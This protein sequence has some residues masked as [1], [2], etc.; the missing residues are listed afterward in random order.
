MDDRTNS[1][2]VAAS[3]NDLDAIRAIIARLED[4]DRVSSAS[5]TSSSCGTPAAA[6]V[7]DV[8]QTF[9]TSSLTVINTGLTQTNYLEII[10]EHRD[11][12]RADHQQPAHQRH[13][14][15]T[16]TQLMPVIEQL[17][18]VPLQVAIEVLIAEV[19]PEQQRGVRRRDRPAEPGP[20]PAVGHP[21]A[22]RPSFANATGGFIPPARPVNSTITQYAG[23][24][25]PFNNVN[26]APPYSNAVGQASSASRG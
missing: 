19:A 9:L 20:V 22:R 2:I 13:A 25:F 26:A 5:R 11:R 23:T 15:G 17:D 16:S 7:A 3:Q 6:D 18:A 14:G 24:A 4:A 12:R 21:D 10:A 8:L 1:I